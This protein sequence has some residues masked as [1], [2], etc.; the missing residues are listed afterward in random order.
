MAAGWSPASSRHVVSCSRI[1]LPEA[2]PLGDDPL[3]VAARQEVTAVER[4]RLLQRRCPHRRPVLVGRP[5][6][7]VLEFGHIE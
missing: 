3:V 1:S 4:C 6:G 7:G 2:L 5:P